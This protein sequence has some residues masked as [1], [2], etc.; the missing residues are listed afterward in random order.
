MQMR[1]YVPQ[2]RVLPVQG[3]VDT[4][5][6]CPTRPTDARFVA[7]DARLDRVLPH[8]STANLRTPCARTFPSVRVHAQGEFSVGRT[9]ESVAAII[10]AYDVRGVVGEQIDEDFV[11][12]VGASFARLVRDE[13]GRGPLWFQLYGQA[14]HGAQ[15]ELLAQIESAGFEAIVLSVDAPVQ[16]VR[17]RERGLGSRL[18]LP[19]YARAIHWQPQP[20]ADSAGLCAGLA[21]Q[22]PTWDDVARL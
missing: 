2:L 21:S 20:P 14:D 10:K 6:F 9:A 16:G 19:E 7:V 8:P 4:Y 3:V 18:P 22:A 17:D 5:A 12:D 11:R 1:T 15:A 13:A